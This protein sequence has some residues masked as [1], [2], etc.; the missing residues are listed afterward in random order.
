MVLWASK[1]AMAEKYIE[2]LAAII[3]RHCPPSEAKEEQP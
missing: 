1:T 2:S 3:A